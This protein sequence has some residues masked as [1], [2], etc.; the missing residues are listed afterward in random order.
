M[1]RNF[2]AERKSVTRGFTLLLFAGLLASC[3]NTPTVKSDFD[4]AAKFASYRTYSWL[5]KPT[6]GSPLTAQRIVDG[7]DAKLQAKGWQLAPDGD[8]RVAANVT[9]TQ[10]QDYHTYYSGMGYGWGWGAMS[11]GMATTTVYTYEVG[12]LVVDMFDSA[13]KRAVWR[14][15]ANGILSD[16]PDKRTEMLQA[17]LDKM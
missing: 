10:K 4:P 5:A 3:A 7:I 16:S 12:T 8:V 13:T 15:S 17:S 2:R 9:S 14:G 11:P 6:G 1:A